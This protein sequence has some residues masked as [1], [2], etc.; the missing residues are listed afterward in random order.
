MLLTLILIINLLVGQLSNAY[1][2]YIKNRNVLMLLETLSVR[3][4]SE[5]DDKY[6][7]SV[8]CPYPISILNLLFGTYILSVKNEFHNEAI[9]HFYFLPVFVV[10]LILFV[11]YII[12]ITPFAYLKT[13]GHKFALI[14]KNP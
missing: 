14:I 11:A 7:A 1:S 10:N 4:A 6:S 2:K 9:L 12:V 3:E 5:A 13:V 8:S